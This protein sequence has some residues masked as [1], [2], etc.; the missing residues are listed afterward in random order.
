MLYPNAFDEAVVRIAMRNAQSGRGDMDALF[1]YLRS[2]QLP[3]SDFAIF[4]S[5]P[6]IIRGCVQGTNDLDVLCRGDAWRKAC[7]TGQVSYDER[8]DVSLA[9]HKNGRITFGTRWGIGEFDTDELIDTAE[10]FE[11]LPFVRVH[12]VIAYKTIRSSAKDQLHLAQYREALRSTD[13]G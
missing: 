12:H 9:S 6:L 10:L 13:C 2:L 11:G 1:D 3:E 4:G 7:A 8:Y 5:G